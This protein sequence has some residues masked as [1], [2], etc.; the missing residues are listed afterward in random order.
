MPGISELAQVAVSVA[1]Q[2]LR[3]PFERIF[4]QNR[5]RGYI[6]KDA[7]II[8]NQSMGFVLAKGSVRPANSLEKVMVL[9]RL[10][11]VHHLQ[12]RASKPVNNL[13][14]Q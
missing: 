7:D 12:N 1:L 13:E 9:H 5:A 10:I 11:Q 8:Y 4:H 6:V 3:P 2:Y 14:S